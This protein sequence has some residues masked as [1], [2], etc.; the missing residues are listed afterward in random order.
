MNGGS[1]DAGPDADYDQLQ[2]DELPSVQRSALLP[3]SGSG[4]HRGWRM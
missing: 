3:R 4:G 2:V 1:G